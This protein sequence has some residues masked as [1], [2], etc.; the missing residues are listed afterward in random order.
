ME[1]SPNTS[2]IATPVVTTETLITQKKKSNTLL[3]V[4]IILIV[5]AVLCCGP[6][7]V[8]PAALIGA[9]PFLGFLSPMLINNS[10]VQNAIENSIESQTDGNLDL[11]LNYDKTKTQPLPTTV[12]QDIRAVFTQNVGNPYNV[13]TSTSE[14]DSYVLAWF[15]I[16]KDFTT[17]TNGVEKDLK[18]AGWT[19]QKNSTSDS[20]Q[21]T[22]VIVGTKTQDGKDKQMTASF[23]KESTDLEIVLTVSY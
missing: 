1:T 17:V 4:I 16:K 6:F 21:Q 15:S 11:G 13:T 12:P 10:T 18:S 8:I 23:T 14:T 7:L 9:L 19:I 2:K 20:N 5:L 3:I 22:I